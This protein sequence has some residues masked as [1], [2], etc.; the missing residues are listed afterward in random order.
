MRPALRTAFHR[1]AS[2]ESAAAEQKILAQQRLKRP[3]APHLSIYRP[4]ITW[5]ASSFHRITGF[6]LSASFYAY[7]LLYLA[8]PWVGVHVESLGL[9]EKVAKLS[10]TTK[11]AIKGILA[12]S[13]T[14]HSFNGVRHLTWDTGSMLTNSAIIKSG[15]TV[16]AISALSTGYLLFQ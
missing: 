8:G 9:K 10:K 13:F 16:V 14:F 11:M 12:T 1:T 15:W 3:I 7:F 6:V 5:Y 4:Q 2:T